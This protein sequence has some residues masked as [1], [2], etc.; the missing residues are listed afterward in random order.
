[1]C[2]ICG[3]VGRAA[4][5]AIGGMNERLSH[6]GP[7]DQGTYVDERAQVALGHKRLAILDLS[8]AGR[9]PMHN[10]DSSLVIVFNG[11]IYNY[12]EL[13]ARLRGRGFSFR[14][15]TDTEVILKL[16]EADGIDC[17]TSL[18]GIFAF[19]VWDRTRNTLFLARDHFGIK[20]LYYVAKDGW[21][22]F[23]SEAK[24]LFALPGVTPEL[25][26]GALGLYFSFLWTPDPV[27][28]FKGVL[29]LPAGHYAEWKNGQFRSARFWDLTFPAAGARQRPHV[30]A[31]VPEFKARFGQAVE[32]Q[33]ISDVPVGAFLSAGLD[34][35]A[36]VA[37]MARR[38]H[39][40]V[41]SYTIAFHSRHRR[42][43][44]TLDDPA[45][46][47]LTA[48]A[49]GCQHTEIV[50]DPD[51][52]ALL[53]GLVWHMDEPTADPAIVMAYLVSREARREVTVLLSGIGGDEMLGGYRKYLAAADARNYQRIPAAVRLGVIDPLL[54]RAPSRPGTAW[55]GYGRLLRKWGRS[56]SLSRR[57]QFITNGTYLPSGELPHLFAP[58]VD[59][60]ASPEFVWQFHQ[61]AFDRVRDAEWL[62]QMMYVDS[63]LFMASLNLSYND[64]M[65]MASGVEVRVPFLDWELAEWLAMVVPPELKIHGRITKYLL[66]KAYEDVFP[67][68]IL[69]A[70]KAGFGAPIGYW[71]LNDLREMVDDLLH[72][73]R[74]RRRG[75]FR[76][77]VV[78]TWIHEQR[79]G[80]VERSWNVWQLLT[81]E[82]WMQAFFDGNAGSHPGTGHSWSAA[83]ASA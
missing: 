18:N 68:E 30:D 9:Q 69:R 54:R 49:F 37:E 79:Q 8:A 63:K 29:K 27:T 59:G 3:V 71:L 20:P 31:L 62:H 23:A 64:R 77:A 28:L 1:M 21:L 47:R 25:D 52:A 34:S 10:D 40:P 76:P 83:M 41:R 56:A 4:A 80:S 13:R 58:G 81:F 78:Q 36:I 55:G 53:P 17:V 26:T 11:E 45:L 70:R 44:V 46:A 2:G 24:S 66:R 43:E 39:H 57:E 14:S 51:V 6:R 50:V 22:A 67:P 7:D 82:L 61:A 74:I 72:P 12:R 15:N 33:L 16:Y 60:D 5:D 38:T 75:L 48:N 35:S 42:G 32:R 19:A 65:S 73:D